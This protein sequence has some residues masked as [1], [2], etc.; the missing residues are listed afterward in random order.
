MGILRSD[1]VSH[2]QLTAANA[3]V[4]FDGSDS[5]GGSTGLRTANGYLYYNTLQASAPSAPS[6][7]S[8]Q[9]GFSTGLLSG[10][11]IGT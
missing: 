2:S 8:V 1:V 4:L 6:N 5:S 3:S 7:S 10:G 11:V 9:Y